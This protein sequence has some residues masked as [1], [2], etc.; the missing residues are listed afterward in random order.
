MK[1]LKVLLA[2]FVLAVFGALPSAQ[3]VTVTNHGE[4]IEITTLTEKI[5]SESDT[6][7]VTL[8][9]APPPVLLSTDTALTLSDAQAYTG[10]PGQFLVAINSATATGRIYQCFAYGTNW[11]LT[12]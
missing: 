10:V 8:A 7:L 11:V 12:K 3:A 9:I 1:S 5:A 2:V 6:N 4:V